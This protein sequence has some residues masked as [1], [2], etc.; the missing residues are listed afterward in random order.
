LSSNNSSWDIL[1]NTDGGYFGIVPLNSWHHFAIQRNGGTIWLFLD[2]VLVNG[3]T[4]SPAATLAASG[5]PLSIGNY[6]NNAYPMNG[7]IDNIRISN[8][9]RYTGNFTPPTTPY[10]P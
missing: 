6:A 7:Y 8:I 2:G 5:N 1:S 9:A 4:I 10:P 3:K